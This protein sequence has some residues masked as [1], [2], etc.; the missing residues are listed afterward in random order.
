[1]LGRH[2]PHVGKPPHVALTPGANPTAAM[3]R[4]GTGEC[5]YQAS[6][7]ISSATAA[8]AGLDGSISGKWPTPGS[9]AVTTSSPL[10]PPRG[11]KPR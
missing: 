5:G 1:M 6:W 9:H 2:A 4:R 7:P 8:T 10:P 11:Q 3:V